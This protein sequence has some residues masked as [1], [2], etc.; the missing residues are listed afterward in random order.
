MQ[1]IVVTVLLAIF[2][3]PA[4]MDAI[5]GSGGLSEAFG[6]PIMMPVPGVLLGAIGRAL[7]AAARRLRAT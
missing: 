3:D 2:H 1:L 4:T 7:G 5:A 6:M